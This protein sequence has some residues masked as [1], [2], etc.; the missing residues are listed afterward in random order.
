[1]NAMEQYM[2]QRELER[3]PRRISPYSRRTERLRTA[4]SDLC[5]LAGWYVRQAEILAAL[6]DSGAV[7][8]AQIV[9]AGRQ[10]Q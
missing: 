9:A 1:M 3:S 6:V 7:T 2:M 8:E 4:D 10:L 5:N